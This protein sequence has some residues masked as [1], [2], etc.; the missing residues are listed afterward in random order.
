MAEKNVLTLKHMGST[1][2]QPSEPLGLYFHSLVSEILQKAEGYGLG[3]ER[4][5]LSL[6]GILFLS[7]SQK[8]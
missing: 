6:Q 5:Q 7:A 4:I 8:Q 2:P 1:A 3:T